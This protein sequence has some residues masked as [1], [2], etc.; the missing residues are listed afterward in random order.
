[1]AENTRNTVWE[2]NARFSYLHPMSPRSKVV[3]TTSLRTNQMTALERRLDGLLQD[4]KGKGRFRQLR[5]YNQ[6]I[7]S[8]LID[9]VRPPYLWFKLTSSRPMTTSL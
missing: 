3:S 1:L 4:R 7:D 6:S 5:E 8:S 2:S 9:F